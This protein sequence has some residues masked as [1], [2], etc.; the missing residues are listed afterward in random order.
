MIYNTL[1][2]GSALMSVRSNV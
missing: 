2:A 1:A